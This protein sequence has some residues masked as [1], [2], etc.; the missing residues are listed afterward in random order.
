LKN[1]QYRDLWV[2]KQLASIKDGSKILDVG[3]GEC[4]YKVNCKHLDYK[5][6]DIALYD[7]KGDGLGLHTK[8]WD[9]SRID[10][11]CDILELNLEIKYDAILCTEVLEH[12]TDPVA[13]LKHLTALLSPDGILILTAP[14]NSVNHFAPHFHCTGFSRYFYSFHCQK[15]GM[16]VIELSSNG[17]FFDCL[18]QELG[19]MPKVR[20]KYSKSLLDPVSFTLALLLRIIVRILASWDGPRDKRRSSELATLGFHLV[21]QK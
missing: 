2:K 1:Y 7:G 4:R 8:A 15:L 21:A 6:Q 3:A 14:F 11:R 9:T 16:K 5:S 10:F 20:F 19:R 18:A 13:V 12:V 17:G